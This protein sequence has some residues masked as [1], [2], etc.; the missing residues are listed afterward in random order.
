MF[1]GLT[2]TLKEF[3]TCRYDI[4]PV[5]KC[6][7]AAT[8]CVRLTEST[9]CPD[10]LQMACTIMMRTYLQDEVDV[11]E[12]VPVGLQHQLAD[13]ICRPAPPICYEQAGDDGYVPD[14]DEEQYINE[15]L[16]VS[17]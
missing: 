16:F 5:I 15:N 1:L 13:W 3:E 9:S 12:F 11:R 17:H 2:F 8:V 10:T 7:Y 4:I 6:R 14:S